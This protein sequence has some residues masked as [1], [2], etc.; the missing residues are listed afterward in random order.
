MLYGEPTDSS[1]VMSTAPSLTTPSKAFA[2]LSNS[3][4]KLLQ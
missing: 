3:G 2:A 4:A 1:V